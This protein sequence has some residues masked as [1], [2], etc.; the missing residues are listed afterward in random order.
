MSVN[1]RNH[2]DQSGSAY[3]LAI[4]VLLILTMVGLSVALTTQSEARIGENERL[5]RRSFYTADAGLA[6]QTARALA[7]AGNRCLNLD[8][9]EPSTNPDLQIR[10]RL[11]MSGFKP[12]QK[13]WCNLCQVNLGSQFEKINHAVTA[14]ATRISWKGTPNNPPQKPK[15]L[16]DERLSVMVSFQPWTEAMADAIEENT[17]GGP[18]G[19]LFADLFVSGSS[20]ESLCGPLESF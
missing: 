9:V 3:L 11:M 2:R 8:F 17:G 12:V 6:I 16:A 18:Q 13:G 5:V 1:R 4:M 10:N 20:A 7:N 15:P 14:Q 19:D